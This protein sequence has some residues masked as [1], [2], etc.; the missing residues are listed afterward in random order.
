MLGPFN[1]FLLSSTILGASVD[2]F[3]HFTPKTDSQ[4]EDSFSICGN[5]DSIEAKCV[6]KQTELYRNAKAVLRIRKSG[7]AHCTGWLVGDQG[8]VLTNNHCIGSASESENL[9]FEAM[10]EGSTCQTSCKSALSCAG[11]IIH[12]QPLEFIATGGNTDQDWTLLR[13]PEDNRTE[14]LA[15]YG[16]VRLRV[17]G[18]IVGEQI[19]VIGHPRG[20]GKRISLNDGASPAT[21]LSTSLDTGCGTSEVIYK[22]DTEGGSSG[23]PVFGANDNLVVAIHHCGGCA[24]DGNSAVDI[25]K[26]YNGTKQYLPESDYVL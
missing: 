17:S 3:K 24:Q 6:S 7:R 9:K 16:F 26:L 10:A 14:V 15:K 2:P 4:K 23:S 8:H 19:Y 25:D 11:T 12:T 13:V 22:A 1:L 21:I 5:D 18:P 20:Y